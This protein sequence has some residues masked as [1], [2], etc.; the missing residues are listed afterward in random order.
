[1]AVP[2][3]VF[4]YGVGGTPVVSESTKRAR[5]QVSTRRADPPTLLSTPLPVAPGKKARLS[6]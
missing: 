3:L 1:M 2:M 6:T 4:C 5:L